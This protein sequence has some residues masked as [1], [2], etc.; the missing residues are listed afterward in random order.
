MRRL[1]SPLVTAV[2][3]MKPMVG[4]AANAAARAPPVA[5]RVPHV[6]RFGRVDGE[7]RGPE[8]MDPPLETT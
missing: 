8:P 6:V 1:L 4:S 2:A 5:R 3:A 7:N